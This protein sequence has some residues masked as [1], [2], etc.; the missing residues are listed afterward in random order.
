MS[1][2]D[3]IRSQPRQSTK[4]RLQTAAELR[5]SYHA[6]GVHPPSAAD[7]PVLE[8]YRSRLQELIPSPSTDYYRAW[9][10]Y[11]LGMAHQPDDKAAASKHFCNAIERMRAQ[12]ALDVRGRFARERNIALISLL[13]ARLD[14]NERRDGLQFRATV[15]EL[16]RNVVNMAVSY[17]QNRA[18]WKLRKELYGEMSES[19]MAGVLLTTVHEGQT[20]IPAPAS[21]RQNS[22]HTGNLRGHKEAIAGIQRLDALDFNLLQYDSASPLAE[23]TDTMAVQVK[24]RMISDDDA[25]RYSCLVLYTDHNLFVNSMA[26]FTSLGQSLIGYARRGCRQPSRMLRTAQS[27]I[28]LDMSLYGPPDGDYD[29]SLYVPDTSP[30]IET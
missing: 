11:E 28:S 18:N 17:R 4:R 10:S 2:Q 27:N 6:Y 16:G 26:E 1:L 13:H 25:D 8:D 14:E 23:A 30:V 22:P 24:S 7:I 15:S 29:Q 3:R 19:A 12:N 9:L 5:A 21:P 20:L